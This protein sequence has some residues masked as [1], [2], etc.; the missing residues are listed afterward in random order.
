[1]VYD[2]Y[3]AALFPILHLDVVKNGSVLQVSATKY[4]IHCAT[5]NSSKAIDVIHIILYSLYNINGK[6]SPLF[7]CG[8]YCLRYG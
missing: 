3:P 8:D 2:L 1:M 4:S 7:L 6:A 5:L